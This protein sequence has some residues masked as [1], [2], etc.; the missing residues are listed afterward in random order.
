M[1]IGLVGYQGSGKSTVFELLTGQQP[2]LAKVQSGQSGIAVVPDARFD[3]LVE[4]HQP[5]KIV[6]SKIELLPLE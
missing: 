6:P 5:K 2:D 3:R 1:K 4:H